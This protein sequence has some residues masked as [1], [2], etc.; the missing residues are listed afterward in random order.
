MENSALRY[1]IYQTLLEANLSD[2]Q[3]E[4]ILEGW[5]DN[6]KSWLGAVKDTGATDIGKIFANNKFNRR[7]KVAADNI[8]KEIQDL[9]SIAKDAGVSPEVALEL[10]N[11][12]LTGAGAEPAK[13][14]KAAESP[15]T[16][17]SG[18]ASAETAAPKSGSPITAGDSSVSTIVKAAAAASG[19][20][21]EKVAAQAQEKK[22]DSPKAS[23][24]LAKAISQQTK[25]NPEVAEKV[26]NWLIKN[27]HLLAEGGRRI[28]ETVILT[29]A[30]KSRT[31]TESI[32]VEKWG[33]IAGL[34]VE[35]DDKKKEAAKKQFGDF[36]DDLQKALGAENDEEMSTEIM[37]ILIALDDLDVIEVK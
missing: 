20:D 25:T 14:E 32:S 7:V 12:I 17:G 4:V 37:D 31:I 3:R 33:K 29:A 22:I 11:S 26:I 16:G 8:T 5:F 13:I 36:L 9:K 21:P 10:L 15:S 30:K 27:N 23:K 24:A 34:I 6:L 2:A 35:A 1:K 19:Q 18:S 28:S